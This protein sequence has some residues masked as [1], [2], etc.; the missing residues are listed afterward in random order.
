MAREIERKFLVRGDGW[1]GLGADARRIVQFYLAKTG[2]AEIRVRII[3]DEQATLTIKSAGAALD[4][5]EHELALPLDEARAM[6]AL[7]V[8]QMIEKT[9]HR[10]CAND[11]HV[12]EVDEFGG[13]HQGLVLAEVELEAASEEP[14]LFDWLG[15]E[16]TGDPAYYNASLA[17]AG[18]AAS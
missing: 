16:V 3:D 4:R 1:R 12:W 5:Q 6:A 9:R 11:G 13:A 17:L 15:E 14:A 10:V 8:G 7:H 2:K 18:G